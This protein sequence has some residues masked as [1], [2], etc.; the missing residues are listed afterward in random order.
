MLCFCLF[1]RNY[2]TSELDSC[3][4]ANKREICRA[5]KVLRN[6]NI[7][8]NLLI[9]GLY[10]SKNTSFKIGFFRQSTLHRLIQEPV[11]LDINL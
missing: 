9:I 10:V 3:I 1:P 6:P 7:L 4:F 2:L 11:I 5:I 8:R